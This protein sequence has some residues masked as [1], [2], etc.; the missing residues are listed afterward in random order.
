MNKKILVSILMGSDSDWEVMKEASDAMKEFGVSHDMQVMSAHRT[1]HEVSDFISR[2]ADEGKKVIIA[3]AGSAA[4]LAGVCA[5]HTILPVI[6]VPLNA[7]SLGGFD[8]LLSTVQMPAGIPVATVAV[9]KSGARN[10]GLLAV[11]ILAT[12]DIALAKKYSDFKKTM[13]EKV[14][15]KNAKLQK[16]II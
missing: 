10:E 5:A 3:G 14:H 4:H 15:E 12:A 1:P 7:T 2:A 8:A 9:G 11:Q 13:A 16:T 6:G